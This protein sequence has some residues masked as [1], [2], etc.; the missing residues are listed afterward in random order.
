MNIPEQTLMPANFRA[1]VHD[2]TQDY[3]WAYLTNM[4]IAIIAETTTMA[5][6]DAISVRPE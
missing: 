4:Y 3:T 5:N 6:T 2:C 1:G